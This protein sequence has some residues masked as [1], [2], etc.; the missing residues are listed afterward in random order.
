MATPEEIGQA[1]ADRI[2]TE[3]GAGTAGTADPLIENLQVHGMM[4]L[5]PTPPSVDVYPDPDAFQ[6]P[7][8]F[9]RGNQIFYFHV[10]ARVTW[11]DPNGGQSLLLS[12]MDPNG[13]RSMLMAITEDRT[14]GGKVGKAS[15][16]EGP[17]GYGEFPGSTDGSG[18]LV[19]CVWRVQ[20]VP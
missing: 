9:G 12:M 2:I 10:R 5:T 19:G 4:N 14:L 8:T 15:V 11:A 18:R 1:I 17:S 16:V 6:E 7:L 3:L 13:P 20:V